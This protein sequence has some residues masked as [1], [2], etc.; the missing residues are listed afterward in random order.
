MSA[1]IAFALPKAAVVWKL[2]V[3]REIILSGFQIELYAP[4]ERSVAYWYLSHVAEQHLDCLET[5]RSLMPPGM[6]G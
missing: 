1:I 4:N 6:S 3:I 2:T 5:L